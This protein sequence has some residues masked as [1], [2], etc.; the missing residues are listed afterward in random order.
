[1]LSLVQQ[2]D[3]YQRESKKSLWKTAFPQV[4]LGTNKAGII[5]SVN[6]QPK[7]R[8]PQEGL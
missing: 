5:K 4:Q 3:K 2:G 6:N 7:S 8:L 1:M